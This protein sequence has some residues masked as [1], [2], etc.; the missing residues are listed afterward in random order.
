[1]SLT[2]LSEFVFT[3]E[4]AEGR[5]KTITWLQTHHLLATRMTCNCGP[6]GMN[7]VRRDRIGTQTDKWAWRCTDSNCSSIKSIHSGSWFEGTKLIS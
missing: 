4:T 7:M 6:A 2:A 5:M 1:M 3:D